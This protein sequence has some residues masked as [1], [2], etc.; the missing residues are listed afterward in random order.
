L[1]GLFPSHRRSPSDLDCLQGALQRRAVDLI[2]QLAAGNAETA[3]GP[4]VV[5]HGEHLA[6]D[7]VEIEPAIAQAS[8]QPALNV[9]THAS[10][11]ALS[12]GF[13][14]RVGRTAVS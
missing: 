1:N 9:I 2:E 5:E 7:G 13:F 8:Q 10:T 4:L 6:D 3:D 11:L 12:R 14:G